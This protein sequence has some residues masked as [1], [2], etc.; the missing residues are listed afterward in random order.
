MKLLLKKSMDEC[1]RL[2][3]EVMKLEAEVG[4]PKLHMYYTHVHTCTCTVSV[5]VHTH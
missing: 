4:N 2:S 5:S 1:M 3:E